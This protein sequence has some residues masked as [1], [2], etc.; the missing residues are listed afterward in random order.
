[1]FCTD[2]FVQNLATIK[3]TGRSAFERS[4]AASSNRSK[5]DRDPAEWMP[6]MMDGCEYVTRWVDVKA[7]WNLTVDPTEKDAILSVLSWCD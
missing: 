7:E 5:G 2:G 1:M 6:T 4:S 3:R